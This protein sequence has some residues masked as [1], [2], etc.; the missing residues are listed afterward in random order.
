MSKLLTEEFLSKYKDNVESMTNF[1]H[2]VYL[3]TYARWL[4]NEGRR[5]TW[6]E[7]VARAVEY[8][9]SLIPGTTK[10]EAEQLFDNIYNL[11]QFLS[12]RTMYSGGTDVSKLY[13]T[14]NFNCAF[15]ILDNFRAFED[16]FYLS[17]VGAGVGFRVLKSDV[18]KLPKVRTDIE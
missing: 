18:D 7:T 12:G 13:P 14:S 11:R 16:I 15:T 8:N 17:M 4:D 3:R 9:C 10:E 6:K 1:G 5:E 2:F